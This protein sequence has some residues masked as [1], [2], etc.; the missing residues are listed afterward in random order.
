MDNFNAENIE[1]FKK[2]A[3]REIDD[4]LE[5][6][7]KKLDVQKNINEVTRL[8]NHLNELENKKKKVQ[9][10]EGIAERFKKAILDQIDLQ[11]TTVKKEL[12]ALK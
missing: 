2:E 8:Q 11:I 9:K 4:D 1:R 6:K 10:N 3:F 7:L 5:K 12:E